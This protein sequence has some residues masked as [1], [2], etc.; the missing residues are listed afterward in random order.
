MLCT[1]LPVTVTLRTDVCFLSRLCTRRC[2]PQCR[3]FPISLSHWPLLPGLKPPSWDTRYLGNNVRRQED[4]LKSTC[5]NPNF[6]FRCPRW[7]STLNPSPWLQ[8]VLL[9]RP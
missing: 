6:L 2:S 4:R 7:P 5:P 8:W 9:L 3:K 1:R